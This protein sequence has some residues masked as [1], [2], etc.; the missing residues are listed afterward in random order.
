MNN[1][2]LT[3]NRNI[4]QRDKRN[5]GNYGG[6]ASLMDELF[7]DELQLAK[8]KDFN[9]GLS[10]P[11]VNIIESDEAYILDMA[12]PGFKKTDFIIGLENE[13]LSIAAEIKVEED[14]KENYTRKEFVYASFKRTF[15]LPETVDDTAINASYTD[16]I[17]TVSIP[18]KEEAKPKPARTIEIS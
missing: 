6:W 11:K 4:L 5:L 8:S 10:N 9:K 13:E 17:L 12:V 7:N 14:T 18:K 1:L 15:L 2:M 16:G 3:K